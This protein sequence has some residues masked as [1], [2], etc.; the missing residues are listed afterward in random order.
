[1]KKITKEKILIVNYE[2]PP[3]GGGGGVAAQQISAEL[4]NKYEVHY[5][6]SGVPSQKK[7]EIVDKIIVHR[8][9]ITNR[10][11]RSTA[12]FVSMLTYIIK[13]IPIGLKLCK[14]HNVKYVW[15]W[16]AIPSGI[17]GD[18]ICRL[19]RKPHNVTI[20]GGDIY[21]PSKKMS[22]HKHWYFRL[23]VN[24]ILKHANKITAISNDTKN[25][26]N[27][28]YKKKIPI[29]VLPLGFIPF[30]FE[31]KTRQELGL[32]KDVFYFAT[33][34]RHVKR[35]GYPY[36]FKALALMKN[37]NTELFMIGDG[38]E[39]KDYNLLCKKLGVEN[40][41]HFLGY[42]S[43]KEKFQY[44]NASNC[45]ILSSL[46]EGF[47]IVLQEAMYCNIPIVATNNGGQTDF[48]KDRINALL[49]PIKNT[50]KLS[51]AM[52]SITENKNLRQRFINHNKKLIKT[53]FIDKITEDYDKF[54]RG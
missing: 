5:L 36:L 34:G 23:V 45:Y 7:L 25:R 22:P 29:K 19:K 11:D 43:E 13:G 51:H 6:T 35:K 10:P 49:V 28:F 8:V 33:V 46:H 21:D 48:L 52:D 39:E 38:P 15:S 2:F 31:K 9:K 54:F 30:K 16:F 27:Y 12:S 14:E 32:K 20:I 24:F 42:I 53:F 50:E 1:M 4:T 41:V 44:L 26:Y 17:V 18:I 47:G 3:L 40:R 37:E